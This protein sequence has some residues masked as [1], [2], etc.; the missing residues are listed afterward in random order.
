MDGDGGGYVNIIVREVKVAPIRARIGDAITIE[1]VV[2]DV[3]DL[4]PFNAD[5]DVYANG[6]VVARKLATY[7]YGGDG[8]RIQRHTFRWDTHGC[9]PGEYRI[10]GEAFVWNDASPFDNDLAV[11]QPLILL[12]PGMPFPGGAKDGG[13]AIARD[14][15]YKPA[16]RAPAEEATPSPGMGGY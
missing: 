5:V 11:P 2:E 12:P 16:A 9:Q 8:G 1:M 6:K 7:G 10:R 13:E 4:A 15:R 14:P 3:G